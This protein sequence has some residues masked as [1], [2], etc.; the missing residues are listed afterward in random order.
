MDHT[1]TYGGVDAR[2]RPAACR[3]AQRG[4]PAPAPLPRAGTQLTVNASTGGLAAGEL[5]RGCRW[6]SPGGCP[7]DM[8]WSSSGQCPSSVCEFPTVWGVC[9]SVRCGLCLV[10]GEGAGVGAGHRCMTHGWWRPAIRSRPRR[11][12]PRRSASPA[13]FFLA[14]CSGLS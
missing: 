3:V 2:A 5:T 6:A 1:Y 4:G 14:D 12:P 9:R 10:V 8:A 7:C 13:A 11:R